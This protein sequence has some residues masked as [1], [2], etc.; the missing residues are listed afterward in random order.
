M[1]ARGCGT[2]GDTCIDLRYIL[3]DKPIGL[4]GGWT[5]GGREREEGQ[6]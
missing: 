2:G 6:G 4:D 5:A 3:E 1:L